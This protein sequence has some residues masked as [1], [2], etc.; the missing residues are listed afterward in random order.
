MPWLSIFAALLGTGAAIGLSQDSQ[1]KRLT[2]R[3][4]RGRQLYIFLVTGSLVLA[5][6]NIAGAWGFWHAPNLRELII[7]VTMLFSFVVGALAITNSIVPAVPQDQRRV[8]LAIGAHPDDLEIACGATLA[9]L[10]DA[11]HEVHVLVMSNGSVG[12]DEEIRNTEALRGAQ[13]MGAKTVR[14]SNLPD[15]RLEEATNE[16]VQAIEN[17]IN[18]LNPDVL[19]THSEHDQ[20]QDH[21]AVHFATLRAA[22]RHSSILC[23]E[24][25]SATRKF[26]PAVFIDIEDY[27]D[28]KIHAVAQHRNQMGKPY[29]SEENVRGI[30]AFRGN[31]A[32]TQFAEG[33]EPVRLLGSSV[34]VF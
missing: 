27:L 22:R 2:R 17:R 13:F 10:A 29:M 6:A 16:M 4:K 34:G 15:T 12:G 19:F 26:N 1:R 23:F 8:V 5:A 9:K 30:A 7:L 28:V 31:Q 25:P 32:K 20:H 24:S 21:H 11:G 33:F 18:E 3:F 14:V